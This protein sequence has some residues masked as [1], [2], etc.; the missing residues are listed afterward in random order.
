MMSEFGG[1]AKRGKIPEDFALGQPGAGAPVRGRS[2]QQQRQ[3]PK[4]RR[5]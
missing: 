3:K 1:M 2:N 5:K 4:R